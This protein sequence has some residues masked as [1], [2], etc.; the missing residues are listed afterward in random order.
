MPNP[1][2]TRLLPVILVLILAVLPGSCRRADNSGA[3]PAP[4][5]EL[6]DLA[7]NRVS[8][9]SLRGRPVLLNFWGTT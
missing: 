9:A 7:G 2:R 1:A 6:P 5:F 3:Q 4:D 8:L